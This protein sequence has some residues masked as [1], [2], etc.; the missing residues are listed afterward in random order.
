MRHFFFTVIALVGIAIAVPTTDEGINVRGIVTHDNQPVAGAIVTLSGQNMKDTTSS[1]GEFA[2][3]KKV[4]AVRHQL[5]SQTE[6]IDFRNGALELTIPNSSPVKIEIFDV[7]GCLI[8]REVSPNVAAGS[9]RMNITEN[10]RASQ[11]LIIKASIGE[12]TMICRYLPLHNDRMSLNTSIQNRTSSSSRKLAKVAAV[13]DSLTVEKEGFITKTVLIESYDTSV[14]ISLTAESTGS[15][16]VEDAGYDLKVTS[17]SGSNGGSSSVLPDPF[18]M[19]NGSQV[20]TMEDWRL[21]RRELLVEI[22]KKILGEKAPP[23]AKIGGT[24]SGSIT[25]TRYEVKVD[26]PKGSCSFGGKVTLPGSGSAPYPAII[27]VNIPG[28]GS[29]SLSP[30]VLESEGVAIMEYFDP[31]GICSESSG[32]FSKGKYFDANPDY[33]GKTGALVAWGWGVSRIIDM[34]EQHPDIIDPTKIGIHGCSRFGKAAF[35]IGAF[36]QRIALGLPLEPGTG[37]PAPLRALPSLGG[38]TL[39]NCN[40]EASWFGPASRSFSGNVAVDMSDVAALYAPR[41]LL[42]MDNAHI[43]HLSY[44]AN[45]LGCAAAME[46]YKAMGREDALWYK[47][48][49]GDGGHCNNR[50]EYADAQKAMIRKFFKGDANATTGGLDKHSNHGNI[51]VDSWTKG[52]KKGTISK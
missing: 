35:V 8:A 49:S 23:P 18:T 36:D 15:K 44:K 6:K 30:K 52:W 3:I 48:N 19:W 34:L 40:G 9:Y 51:N 5:V 4:V 11:M 10:S 39:S 43:A 13:L 32:N 14:T 12:N 27:I 24:V 26:N 7:T 22:E 37:G 25:A 47:G 20:A 28:F 33:K 31:Y 41:G 46:V 16:S 45:Y 38:Q 21:R 17:P 50:A 42:M 29:H 2:I 1:N